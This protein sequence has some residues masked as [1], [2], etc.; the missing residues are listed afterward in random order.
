[1]PQPEAGSRAGKAEEQDECKENQAADCDVATR[2][3]PSGSCT[4]NW[5][6]SLILRRGL[7]LRLI[8]ILIRW[9]RHTGPAERCATVC[10]KL[11]CISIRKPAIR[12]IHA[13]PL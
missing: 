10:T 6:G 1:M 2:K 5:I 12:T 11:G 9:R 7:I 13:Y 3:P 8:L 4:G